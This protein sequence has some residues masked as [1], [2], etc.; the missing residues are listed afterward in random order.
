MTKN[1]KYDLKFGNPSLNITSAN[2][3]RVNIIISQNKN[4]FSKMFN[5]Y[6][7]HLHLK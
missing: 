1:G 4:G 2:L 5:S 6:L 3:F 7:V